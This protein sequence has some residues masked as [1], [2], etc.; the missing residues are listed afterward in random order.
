M[1]G[2]KA[3]QIPRMTLA[4]AA[5]WGVVSLAERGNSPGRADFPWVGMG[6]Q[7]VTG[8]AFCTG[9]IKCNASEALKW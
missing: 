6:I 2:D 5:G 3:R 8:D 7:G 4:P 1:R 9:H